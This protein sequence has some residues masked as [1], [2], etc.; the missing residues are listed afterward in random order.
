MKVTRETKQPLSAG[1]VAKAFEGVRI[2]A[3]PAC[4]ILSPTA[5]LPPSLPA[6]L[7]P[8]HPPCLLPFSLPP[9]LPPSSSSQLYQ[10]NQLAVKYCM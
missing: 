2:C 8:F 4:L 10:Q 5:S 1:E 6:S 9:S 3:F 7:Q